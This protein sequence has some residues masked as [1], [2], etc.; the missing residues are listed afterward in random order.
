V[1]QK[2]SI[3]LLTTHREYRRKF[4]CEAEKEYSAFFFFVSHQVKQ[5]EKEY[6]AAENE[7]SAIARRLES[8]FV[9]FQK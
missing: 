8:F 7:Y 3:L 2:K 9:S 6:S 5:A 1:K 4:I